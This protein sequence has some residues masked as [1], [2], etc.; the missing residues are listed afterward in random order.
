MKETYE[1]KVRAMTGDEWD[2][3]KEIVILGRTLK[4]T[5]DKMEYRADD[6]HVRIAARTCLSLGIPRVG[7][8]P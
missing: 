1:L 5:K 2:D 7:S 3:D 8:N 6:K 4:W